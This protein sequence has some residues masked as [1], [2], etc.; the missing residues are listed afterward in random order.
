MSMEVK[1]PAILGNFSRHNNRPSSDATDGYGH[2]GKLHFQQKNEG[3]SIISEIEATPSRS[4][5]H[6]HTHIHT[7]THTYIHTHTYTYTYIA[8]FI[9]KAKNKISANTI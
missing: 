8:G 7:H 6:T 1:L 2:I 4:K 3:G 9:A 5:H